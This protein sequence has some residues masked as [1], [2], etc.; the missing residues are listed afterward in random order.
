[1][2]AV[3]G[4]QGPADADHARHLLRQMLRIRRLEEKCVE[5]YSAARIRGFLHVYIGEEA[6]AAGVLEPLAA[7]DCV[8]A[9]YREHGH[10]LLRGSPPG[11]S[12]PRCTAGLKDAAAA[13]AARC[14]SLMPLPGS[15]AEM[16]SSPAGCPSPSDWRWL[17]K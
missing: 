2:T 10:A 15:T 7:E 4:S 3:R 9:T 13:G 8:V 5:L 6:V 11:P 17:T 14:T 12:L 1:M 16:R